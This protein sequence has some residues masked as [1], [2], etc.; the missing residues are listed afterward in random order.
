MA[1]Q[2]FVHTYTYPYEAKKGKVIWVVTGGIA[3]ITG[4]GDNQPQ[5]VTTPQV[6]H[7]T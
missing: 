5:A 6:Q 3:G 1:N 7:G 4:K 2:G